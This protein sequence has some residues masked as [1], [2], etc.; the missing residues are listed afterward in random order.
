VTAPRP[1]LRDL[2]VRKAGRGDARRPT[3]ALI[4]LGV[5][6]VVLGVAVGGLWW[7]GHR[8]SQIRTARDTALQAAREQV[9]TVLSYDFRSL[10]QDLQRAREALTGA[11]LEEFST[12]ANQVTAPAAREQ[13]ITTEADVIASAVVRTD[14]ARVGDRW[15]ISELAR[16]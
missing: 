10:D 3:R 9:V 6:A 11:Y 16:V 8:E 15:L 7:L 4:A 13:Q 5:V 14:P 2:T 12:Q 1:V